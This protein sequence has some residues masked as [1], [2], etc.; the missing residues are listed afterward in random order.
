MGDII[1]ADG[2]LEEFDIAHKS[3]LIIIPVGATGYVAK[4]L[5]KK[6]SETLANIVKHGSG[7]KTALAALN[8]KGTSNE[9]VRRIM[10]VNISGFTEMIG[11]AGASI[12]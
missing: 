3:G 5:H 2:M 7:L 9:I 11:L 1:L 4:R 6:V 12:A 8:K 10:K